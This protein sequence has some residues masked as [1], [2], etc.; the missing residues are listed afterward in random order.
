MMRDGNMEKEILIKLL[1]EEN[2]E[3]KKEI[4]R[5]KSVLRGVCINRNKKL[6]IYNNFMKKRLI[7]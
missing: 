2:E 5:L 1:S 4:K 7:R 6:K 3:L